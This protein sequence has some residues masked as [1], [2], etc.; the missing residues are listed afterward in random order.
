[1]NDDRRVVIVVS[2]IRTYAVLLASLGRALRADGIVLYMFNY[3]RLALF[4]RRKLVE[5]LRE[6]LLRVD[7]THP[8][9]PIDFV[10]VDR[11]IRLVADA[12]SIRPPRIGKIVVWSAGRLRMEDGSKLQGFRFSAS[13]NPA[14]MNAFGGQGVRFSVSMRVLRARM[15]SLQKRMR[16]RQVG[17]PFLWGMASVLC[18]FP[19]GRPYLQQVASAPAEARLASDWNAVAN[20]ITLATRKLLET[21]E[22][23]VTI[24][25]ARTKQELDRLEI[26]ASENAPEV[27]PLFESLRF[28][29]GIPVSTPV[30]VGL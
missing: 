17:S 4:N 26:S 21:H 7:V 14:G 1:L 16:S 23:H 11:N 29:L 24:L 19:W 6:L 3:G 12:L 2:G 22:D 30:T 25:S 28:L 20:A 15:R 5:S 9:L 8:G 13:N 18:L 10:L 27:H